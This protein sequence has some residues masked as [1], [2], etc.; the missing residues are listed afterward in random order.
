[1]DDNKLWK[2]RKEMGIPDHFA[3]LLRNLHAGQ[4]ATVRTGNR[5]IDCSKLEKE[6]VKALYCHTTYL[7]Y[8]Q[9]IS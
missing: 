9:S 5:A 8:I 3:Y 4:Q 2:I 7:I 1:M 6:Y